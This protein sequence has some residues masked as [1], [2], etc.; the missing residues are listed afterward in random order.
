LLVAQEIT[1][2]R[3]PR[4]RVVRGASPQ[5]RRVPFSVS[6]TLPPREH[7][8][9]KACAAAE[10]RSLSGYVNRVIVEALATK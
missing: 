5:D 4:P 10:L 3:G 7:A 1:L 2:D 8:R 6:F 9:I